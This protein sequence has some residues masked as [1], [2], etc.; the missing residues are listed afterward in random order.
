MLEYLAHLDTILMHFINVS[1]ANPVTDFLMPLITDDIFLRSLYAASIV[2]ILWKGDRRLRWMVLFS[3][4]TLA[5][6]DTSVNMYLKHWFGRVRPCHTL[7]DLRVLVNCGAGL[8]MPSSHAANSF[9]QALLF[10][11]PYPKLR[12]GLI[13][14]AAIVALSRVFVGVHYPF[15]VLVGA[16]VG[17]LIGFIVAKIYQRFFPARSE[18]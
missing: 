14:F 1:L 11:V 9:G 12:W 4:L 13:G 15:D 18:K 3:A 8:S 10:A 16:L 17:G 6:T 5:L 7:V 2:I